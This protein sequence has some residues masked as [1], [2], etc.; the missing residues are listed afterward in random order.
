MYVYPYILY[1]YIYIYI[2]I[3]TTIYANKYRYLYTHIYTYIELYGTCSSLPHKQNALV[4]RA[5]ILKN[6]LYPHFLLYIE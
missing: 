1:V 4:I 6:R 3:Y 5:D 2:Y